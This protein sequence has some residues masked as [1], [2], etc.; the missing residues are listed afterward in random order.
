MS[1]PFTTRRFRPAQ[2]GQLHT[3]QRDSH[4][5]GGLF[6]APLRPPVSCP[7][8]KALVGP[9]G[10]GAAPWLQPKGWMNVWGVAQV[11]AG[12]AHPLGCHIPPLGVRGRWV[13][14]TSRDWHRGAL[15]D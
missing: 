12:P 2:R 8:S 3:Y 5:Q 9:M 7:R 1:P 10:E 6:H 13:W 15:A 11:R 14:L 4:F